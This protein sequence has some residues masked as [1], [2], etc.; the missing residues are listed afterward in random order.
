MRTPS[1]RKIRRRKNPL[2]AIAII[3]C[4]AV[5]AAVLSVH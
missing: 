2:A 5:I 4:L 1:H 3:V